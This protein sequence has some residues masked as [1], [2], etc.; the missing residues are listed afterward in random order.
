VAGSLVLLWWLA[1]LVC[2][3]EGLELDLQR[4]RYPMWEWLFSHPLDFGHIEPGRGVINQAAA[5]SPSCCYAILKP[6][7]SSNE[8][9]P[10]ISFLSSVS[11][12]RKEGRT[13]FLRHRGRA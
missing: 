2:Q 13:A 10:A 8:G 4:R 7:D 5:A 3:G 1:M 6:R 12:S 9:F 11:R